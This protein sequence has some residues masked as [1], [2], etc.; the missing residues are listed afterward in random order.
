MLRSCLVLIKL[1]EQKKNNKSLR[2]VERKLN[3]LELTEVWNDEKELEKVEVY[4]SIFSM[5]KVEKPLR[6]G[7]FTMKHPNKDGLYN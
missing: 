3:K 6:F 5:E 7:K 1:S 2:H 4:E